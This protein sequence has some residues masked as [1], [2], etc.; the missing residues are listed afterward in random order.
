MASKQCTRYWHETH[1]HVNLSYNDLTD[2]FIIKIKIELLKKNGPPV[3]SW[4]LLEQL[5]ILFVFLKNR[6]PGGQKLVCLECP[7]GVYF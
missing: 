6:M 4:T 7:R 3:L 2:F 1:S 5:S